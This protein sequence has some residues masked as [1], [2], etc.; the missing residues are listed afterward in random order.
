MRN[1][2]VQVVWDYVGPYWKYQCISS[3][4]FIGTHIGYLCTLYD[5]AMKEMRWIGDIVGVNSEDL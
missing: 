2:H 1:I 3:R 4:S 5:C